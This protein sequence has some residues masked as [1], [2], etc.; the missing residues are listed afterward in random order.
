MQ[1]QKND[2]WSLPVLTSPTGFLSSGKKTI[3]VE[4]EDVTGNRMQ[5]LI[6]R[7]FIIN[8]VSEASK[9]LV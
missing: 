2:P 3:Y 8:N 1:L 7:I 4:L 5:N 6:C 9:S